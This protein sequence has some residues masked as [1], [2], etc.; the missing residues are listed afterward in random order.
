MRPLLVRTPLASFRRRSCALPWPAALAPR[1]PSLPRRSNFWRGPPRPA[2]SLGGTILRVR[3]ATRGPAMSA[4]LL[5]ASARR[6]APW[7]PNETQALPAGYSA[8]KPERGARPSC[9]PKEKTSRRDYLR[10]PA[11]SPQRRQTT[12]RGREDRRA[13]S[14]AA[15]LRKR[16]KS[17]CSKPATG[18]SQGAETKR[19]KGP[20]RETQAFQLLPLGPANHPIKA[21]ADRSLPSVLS[22][23]GPSHCT[24]QLEADPDWRHGRPADDG[25]WWS[26]PEPRRRWLGAQAPA[27]QHAGN[28]WAPPVPL[29]P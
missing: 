6:L 3:S 24:T 29:V 5:N 14:P 27:R 13:I 12:P 4:S 11:S 2:L 21:R 7:R 10:T 8:P 28:P 26:W 19:P 18:L 23:I 9:L 17:G 20:R 22:Q 15:Q 1:G 25:L 16:E